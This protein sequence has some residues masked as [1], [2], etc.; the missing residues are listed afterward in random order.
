METIAIGKKEF[1]VTEMQIDQQELLFYVDNP[2]VYSALRE[3]GNENP[4][5][6]EIEE[7]MRS[8]EHVR[9]LRFQIEQNGGLIEAL[10]VVKRNDEYV[11]LEGNSRLAAYRILADND[12]VKWKSVR[13][14]VLPETITENEIFTLLGTLH[15]VKKKDWTVYEQAAYIYRQKMVS[16]L[17]ISTLAKN[18]GLSSATVKK[19]I[20]VYEFMVSSKDNVQSHWNYYEQYVTNTGIKKYR[21][22]Y[23]EMDEQIVSQIKTGKIKEAK[24]IRD[25]LGKIAKSPDKTAKR[26]M[27]DVIEGNS[28]IEQGYARFEAT[29]KSGNSYKKIKEFRDLMRDD[30]FI[31]SIKREVAGNKATA[32]ELRKLN[33]AITKLLKELGED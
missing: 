23:P 24:V 31:K 13:C 20:D 21:E 27:R 28:S 5:Q 4:T 9:E 32:L 2:R 15:L 19:Y 10:V 30:D 22:T 33:T 16:G 17:P 18:V 14:N 11:V 8:M 3:N 29:G 1:Q 6:S 7:K 25:K 12:P 26:I